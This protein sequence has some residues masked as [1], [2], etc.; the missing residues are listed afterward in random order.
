[1]CIVGLRDGIHDMASSY[2]LGALRIEVYVFVHG[3]YEE[4][5]GADIG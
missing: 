4:L 2:G 1:M 5:C 3:R